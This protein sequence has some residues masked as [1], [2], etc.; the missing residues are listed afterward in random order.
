MPTA[1]GEKVYRILFWKPVEGETYHHSLRC[2]ARRFTWFKINLT[3]AGT[4]AREWMESHEPRRAAEAEILQRLEFPG[5]AAVSDYGYGFGAAQ[6]LYRGPALE[7]AYSP[8]STFQYA[9]SMKCRQ[10]SCA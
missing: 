4:W 5:S 6:L 1:T 10:L 3:N 7:F 2:N 9:R 8:S